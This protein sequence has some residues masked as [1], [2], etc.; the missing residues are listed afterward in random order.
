LK[1]TGYYLLILAA[2]VFGVIAMTTI[3]LAAEPNQVDGQS[4]EKAPPQKQE[5]GEKASDEEASDDE[6]P[7]DPNEPKELLE[8][9]NLNNIEMKHIVQKIADWTQKPVIPTS[10]DVM[11]VKISIYSPK[12]VPRKEALMLIVTAL[13]AKG[14]VVDEMADKVFL[15]PLASVRLG[16]V[17]TL[18][19]DEPLARI[20]DKT[21][22]VE[23]WFQLESYSPSQLIQIINPLIAEYGYA[24]ADETTMQVAVIDTVENLMRIER[25]I[26]QLDIPE[27]GQEVERM[28][29]LKYADPLEVVQVLELILG[30]DRG[31]RGGSPRPSSS[32]KSKD[33]KNAVVVVI[34]STT[35][36]IRIIPMAKQR[37]V[38][39]RASRDDMANIEEWIEKLDIADSDELKQVV[40]QVRYADVR[41]VARMVENTIQEMPGTD[42]E[43]NIVVES[44][45]QSSQI[46]V[47][48]SEANRKIVERLIAQIDLPTADVFEEKT[49][50]LK[51]ADPDTIKK[52]IDELYGEDQSNRN[53]YYYYRYAASRG[54]DEDTVKVISYPML[55]QVTVIASEEN[56]RK[57]V[58]QIEEWDKP[59]DIEADQYR[60]LYLRNSD[61]VQMAT[62]LQ[63]LFSEDDSGGDS[64][65]FFRMLFYGDSGDSRKKIVGSLYG[66]LT[67]EPVPG[68]KKLM[69]ISKIP[70][71]YDVIE[72]LVEKLDGQEK[73]EVP[74][75]I[76]LN[77][78]D[79]EDLCEQLNAIL[80]E[81]GTPATIRRKEHGLSAYT[82]GDQETGQQNATP[83][84][85]PGT[86]NLWWERQRLDRT[87]MPSSNLIGQ[88]R[89][90]PVHRSKAIL[91]LAPPE[92]IEEIE[93]MIHQLDKPGMQ[94]MIKAIIAD[95][96]LTD[97]SSLGVQLASDPSAFGTLGVNALTA[98]NELAFQ[99]AGSSFSFAYGSDINVL[100]DLLI[101]HANGRILNQPT[102]WTKDNEE[103]IF[104]KGQKI[105]FIESD[106]TDSS[107]LGNTKRTF[108]YQDVGVTLRIRPNITPERAVDMTINL[109][110]SE[111]EDELINTQVA[112]KNLDTTTHLIVNDGQSIMMGGILERNDGIVIQKVPLLGDLPLLGALFRHEKKDLTNTELLIFITPYVIDDQTLDEIPADETST[113]EFLRQ[114]RMKM[115]DIVDSL[116]RSVMNLS[117]DPNDLFVGENREIQ[118]EKP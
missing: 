1:R 92:Y 42:M 102:L 32:P 99:E 88:I 98:L 31:R 50:K 18:G 75:V 10:D 49:F 115:D 97:A 105:A 17:A 64:R 80:N 96:G 3:G 79:A 78:A 74:R 113:D 20:E 111:V 41:E 13:H 90:V 47:Y 70:E 24:A 37:W 27:S 69:V 93:A 60:I 26:K 89:F 40:I 86:M 2:L 114:N 19:A 118:T 5:G 48:G 83:E 43:A 35:T 15:R 63:K 68:T 106:N 84:N 56:L 101:K 109:N 117:D 52:N 45:P 29:E 110:I 108:D 112:R 65:S 9:V 4:G 85:D 73:A 100:L 107:N 57:I 77:Y 28:F 116:S 22:I 11:K 76:T 12:K 21:T 104:V 62:L 53:S 44:L 36:P 61:P 67:F 23:K 55:K 91:V 58:K 14:V 39:V 66:T 7:A 6:K 38:L 103:A 51:H 87:Q 59:L 34:G 33:S 16:S 82:P 72:R 94:V 81:P 71:A 8:A 46:V 25:L 54:D 95:V 30:Q